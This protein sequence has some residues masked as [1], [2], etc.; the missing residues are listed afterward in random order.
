VESI[1]ATKSLNVEFISSE[2]LDQTI[3]AKGQL[4]LF[5]IIQEQVTNVLK[6][7]QATHLVIELVADLK[8][9]SLTI[10]DNG[11]GFDKEAVKYKKGLGLHNIANRTELFN[12]KVNMI[13]SPGNGCKLN[14]VIPV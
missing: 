6:H 4:M 14:V 7:A 13:T 10:T 2:D 9:I 12:G 1:R 5:R 8:V 3:N 11:K